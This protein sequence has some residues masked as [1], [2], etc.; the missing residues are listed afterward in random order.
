MSIPD[1]MTEENEKSA[2][3]ETPN[4]DDKMEEEKKEVSEDNQVE[5]KDGD[6]QKEEKPKIDP[7]DWPLTGIKEPSDNDVLFGRGGE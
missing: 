2:A 5:A 6:D 4:G 3:T 7:K 1:S